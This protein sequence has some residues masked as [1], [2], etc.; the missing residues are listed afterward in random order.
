MTRHFL[1]VRARACAI[2]DQFTTCSSARAANWL[3][4]RADMYRQ[5]VSSSDIF[6]YIFYGNSYA[7]EIC[8]VC[9][10]NV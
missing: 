2:S 5:Y 7:L 6:Y 1:V 10:A 8:A 4:L 3:I 9:I